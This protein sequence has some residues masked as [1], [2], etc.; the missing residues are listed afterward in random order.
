MTRVFMWYCANSKVLSYTTTVAEYWSEYRQFLENLVL[1]NLSYTDI[2]MLH[3]AA[4]IWQNYLQHSVTMA[5][6]FLQTSIK[7]SN[8]SPAL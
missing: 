4:W 5:V 2:Y 1:I 3:C 7:L 6:K 8:T